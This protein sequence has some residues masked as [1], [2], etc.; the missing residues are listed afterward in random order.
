MGDKIWAA[1]PQGARQYKVKSENDAFESAI[2]SHQKWQSTFLSYKAMEKSFAPSQKYRPGNT[3]DRLQNVREPFTDAEW[4][5]RKQYRSWDI[6]KLGYAGL[7]I[8]LAYR[9]TNEWPV[10]WCEEQE[11]S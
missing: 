9:A 1:L 6:M 3:C 2:A 7:A 10:V 11:G 4:A 8:F 5:E